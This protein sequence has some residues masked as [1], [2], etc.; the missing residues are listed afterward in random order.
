M[1]DKNNNTTGE[2]EVRLMTLRFGSTDDDKRDLSGAGTSGTMMR[3][4][5]Y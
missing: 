2:G 5:S 1:R 3:H 4:G